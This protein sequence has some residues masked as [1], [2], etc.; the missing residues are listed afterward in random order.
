MPWSGTP[1]PELRRA[2]CVPYRCSGA[3]SLISGQRRSAGGDTRLLVLAASVLIAF[4]ANAAG[5]FAGITIVL[6]HLLYLPIVLGAYWFPRRGIVFSLALALGYL[7]MTLLFAGGDAGQVV[8]AVTRGVVFVAIGV[9]VSLLSLRLREQEERY[10]GIFD[11]S[12]A[13]TFIV[14][15]GEA[16]PQIEEANYVGATLLGSSTKNL[17]GEPVTGLLDDPGA[18]EEFE[19][20]INRN[21]TVYEYETTLRRTDG[22][23]AQVLASGGRLPDGRIIV[24]LVDIT[25][26]KNA[27]DALRRT[28]TKLNMLG[29]L[30]RDDLMAAVSGLLGRIAEGTRQFDDPAVRRHLESLSEDARLVQRRAEITRDYQDL[31]LRPPDWQPLQKMILEV[32]SSL[33]LPGIT[34]RPWVERLE[35]FADPMLDRVF[36]NL[37]ENAARHGKTVSSVVVT[38]RIRDDGLS[39]CVEDDGVGVPERE[40]EKIFEYGI[41]IDGGLGLFLVREILAITKMTIR[42]AGKPGKGA[43]FVIHVPPDGY[44]II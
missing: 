23:A 43:R 34:V 4:A 19:A 44:R 20:E 24:T 35:V 11:Y 28:N 33:A 13:G 37:I 39:I 18:W 3:S 42:E 1:C 8:S 5:L 38:Y 27:E 31:G 16:G 7:A 10:R 14:A 9:V 40:K 17:I 30:T 22:A 32:T 15:P 6:P 21:N 41:G 36:S 12:E 25:A 26:R 2:G 29:R